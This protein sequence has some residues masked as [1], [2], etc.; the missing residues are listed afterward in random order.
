[1]VAKKE[2]WKILPLETLK[3]VGGTYAFQSNVTSQDFKGLELVKNQFWKKVLIT[4]LD[5]NVHEMLLL[6]LD[7]MI[8]NN[9]LIKYKNII[10]SEKSIRC[11]MKTLKDFMP[12]GEIITLYKFKSQYG[13]GA[14]AVLVYNTIFNALNSIP[15]TV[16]INNE[17]SDIS[18][19]MFCNRKVGTIGRKNILDIIKKDQRPYVEKFW[20]KKF[21]DF[22]NNTWMLAY[23]ATTETKLQILQ[24]KILQNIYPT[25][26]YLKKIGIK[27]TD[28]C[29]FCQ[30]RETLEHFF[31]DCVQIKQVW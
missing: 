14:D 28:G 27:E 30:C 24:W 6:K 23:R 31:I 7:D 22:D 16:L 10:F 8:F 5:N 2:E 25:A 20:S 9:K 3:H 29:S 12:S 17:E 1:M 15:K 13:N 4:W 26:I 19:F 18:A 11:G 21:N